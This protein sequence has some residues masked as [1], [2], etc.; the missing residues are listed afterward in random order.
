MLSS[1]MLGRKRVSLAKVYFKVA[2]RRMHDAK[3]KAFCKWSLVSELAKVDKDRMMSNL[4][5]SGDKKS[6]ERE[7]QEL[8]QQEKNNS[9]LKT[10]VALNS[11]PKY[12]IEKVLTYS[13]SKELSKVL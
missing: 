7:L 9:V 11:M 13:N 2:C 5:N 8:M 10:S 6:S 12:A 4:R 1:R 3:E